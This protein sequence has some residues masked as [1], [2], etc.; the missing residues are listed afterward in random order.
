MRNRFV[1]YFV[2][3]VLFLSLSLGV[4]P[5]ASAA[6]TQD[7]STDPGFRESIV[8]IVRIVREIVKKKAGGIM[9]N[10]DVLATPRP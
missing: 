7:P 3:V 1:T 4:A 9:A 2:V 10:A 5:T 6:A 8:R